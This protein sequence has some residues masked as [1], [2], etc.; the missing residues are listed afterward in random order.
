MPD[1]IR[2]NRSKALTVAMALALSLP[3]TALP[4]T[5]LAQ[6]PAAREARERTISVSGHGEARARP[7]EAVLTFSVLAQG[8]SAKAAV[9]AASE[10][11]RGVISAMRELGAGDRDLQTATIQI[12]PRYRQPDPTRQDAGQSMEIVGYDAS[13]TL[14]VTVRDIAK[15]GEFL[16]KAVAE[17]VNEGGDVRFQISDDEALLSEARRNAV[18]DGKAKAALYAEAAGVPL[19]D[20]VSISEP[21]SGYRPVE[22]PMMRMAA[23]SADAGVPIEAGELTRSAAIEMVFSLGR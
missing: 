12:R 23:E 5:A 15:V 9:D 3:A 1:P 13:N 20:L 19:G 2:T 18:A 17:G 11:M 4:Q 22:A 10:S 8:D 7:D 21:S 14:V 16:D 6:E